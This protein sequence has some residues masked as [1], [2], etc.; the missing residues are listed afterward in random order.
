MGLDAAGNCISQGAVLP[1]GCFKPTGP[2]AT[3]LA[4]FRGYRK[5]GCWYLS[6]RDMSFGDHGTICRWTIHILN[7]RIVGIETL[8]WANIKRL[9]D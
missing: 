8:P 6:V 4:A 9:Y 3:P 5:G 2:C 7:D 1:S